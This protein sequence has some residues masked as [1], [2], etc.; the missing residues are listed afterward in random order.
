MK[1]STIKIKCG[2]VS[3]GILLINTVV[4]GRPTRLDF[5]RASQAVY[6]GDHGAESFPSELCET[7][8]TLAHHRGEDGQEMPSTLQLRFHVGDENR[9]S[10][11]ITDN[12]FRVATYINRKQQ[13]TIIAIRGT[14]NEKA[15]YHNWAFN[16]GEVSRG[17]LSKKI[18]NKMVSHGALA[19]AYGSFDVRRAA[20]MS[21][22]ASALS[23]ISSAQD[24]N[25]DI[26]LAA[27]YYY[28]DTMKSAFKPPHDT[29]I[30]GHSMGGFL[31]QLF[32]GLCGLEG[33]SFNAPALGC[34]PTGSGYREQWNDFV[35]GYNRQGKVFEN[36]GLDGD[37]VSLVN[38][39]EGELGHFGR[40]LMV[41]RHGFWDLKSVIAGPAA[42]LLS[43]HSME[44]MIK[45]LQE[46]EDCRSGRAQ[47]S[48]ECQGVDN[49][50]LVRRRAF[51]TV[52]FQLQRFIGMR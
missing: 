42:Y 17:G 15:Y 10:L 1:M 7:E 18:G 29:Y 37:L 25:A 11:G 51:S 32:A 22:S 16:I 28:I 39:E 30:T 9:E 27:V 49:R 43:F 31:A 35:Q 45:H 4:L 44:L 41:H 6:A 46:T 20:A 34:Y 2:L 3:L 38:T 12:A 50:G 23:I 8:Y 36:H 13:R 40:P 47:R 21:V 48:E 33:A 14:E 5:A 24:R 19:V 26:T 52:V